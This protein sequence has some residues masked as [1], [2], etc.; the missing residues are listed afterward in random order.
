MPHRISRPPAQREP[1][2]PWAE[3]EAEAA[4]QGCSVADIIFDRAGRPP[5]DAAAPTPPPPGAKVP[6][7]NRRRW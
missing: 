6:T 3:V 7:Q 1:L 4:R 5:G 2:L